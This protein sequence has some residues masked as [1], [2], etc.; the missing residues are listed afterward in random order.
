LATGMA[1]PALTHAP[2]SV[3]Q[4]DSPTQPAS[5]AE[6]DTYAIYWTSEECQDSRTACANLFSDVV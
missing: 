5:Y 4:C 2:P 1:E 6:T 3:S